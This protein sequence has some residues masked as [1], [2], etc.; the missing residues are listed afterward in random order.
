MLENFPLMLR[1]VECYIMCSMGSDTQLISK[2]S[3][4]ED[5]PVPL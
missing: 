4:I 1:V 5:I 2:G 3:R